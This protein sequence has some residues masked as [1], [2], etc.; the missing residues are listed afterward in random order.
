[1]FPAWAATTEQLPEHWHRKTDPTTGRIYYANELNNHTTYDLAEVMRSAKVPR[2]RT[3]VRVNST[4]FQAVADSATQ[5]AVSD[6]SLSRSQPPAESIATVGGGAHLRG[7]GTKSLID[8]TVVISWDILISNVLKAVSD[9]NYA[10]KNRIVLR[11][12]DQTYIVVRAV[13]DMLASAGCISL[14][15]PIMKDNPDLVTKLKDIMKSISRL[16]LAANV[17]SGVWPPPDAPE[18]LHKEAIEVLLCI[19]NFVQTAQHLN[20]V[21][22]HIPEDEM[23]Q[24]DLNGVALSDQE[25][26]AQLE[27]Y[28]KTIQSRL[29][30]IMTLAASGARKSSLPDMVEAVRQ[31]VTSIGMMLSLLDDLSIN[32]KDDLDHLTLKLA[33]VK[34][35][36]YTSA[37]SMVNM[38]SGGLC[39]R[40]SPVQIHASVLESSTEILVDADY[41]VRLAKRVLDRK[42]DASQLAWQRSDATSLLQSDLSVLQHLVISLS[43]NTAPTPGS[44]VV[45]GY[46]PSVSGSTAHPTVY[47]SSTLGIVE[48]QSAVSDHRTMVAAPSTLASDAFAHYSESSPD[49]TST[50][51]IA[52][53]KTMSSSSS[54]V[55]LGLES[56][57]A[58]ASAS[59]LTHEWSRR[60]GSG[61]HHSSASVSS[62]PTK[63]GNA[64]TASITPTSPPQSGSGMFSDDDFSSTPASTLYGSAFTPRSSSNGRSATTPTTSPDVLSRD[65]LRQVFGNVEVQSATMMELSGLAAAADRTV[66]EASQRK[67]RKFFGD[68]N[69][70]AHSGVAAS[71][72]RRGSLKPFYLLRD[73]RPE[74]LIVSIDG[75]ITG[76]T[77]SALVEHLTPSD[78]PID[79]EYTNAFLMTFR[80]FGT[81]ELFFNTLAARFMMTP[82]PNL[83]DAET[84]LWVEKKRSPVQMR[85]V[86]IIRFWLKKYWDD[87]QDHGCLDYIYRFADSVMSLVPGSKSQRIIELVVKK[88]NQ[89][90]SEI[91]TKLA[92]LTPINVRSEDIPA[93]I[94]PRS[95]FH[96]TLFDIDPV[97]VARQLTLIDFYNFSRI[98][99]LDLLPKTRS[100]GLDTAAYSAE[101]VVALKNISTNISGWVTHTILSERIPSARGG[102]I[103]YFIKIADNCLALGNFN[104]A[105]AVQAGLQCAAIMR[106][107]QSWQT[108]SPK[109]RMRFEAITK[110]TDPSRNFGE[111]RTQLR[112]AALPAIPFIGLVLTDLTFIME[113]NPDYKTDGRLINFDKFSKIARTLQEIKRFQTVPYALR[114]VREIQSFLKGKI[115]REGSQ[116]CLEATF[117]ESLKLEPRGLMEPEVPVKRS[118]NR[119]SMLYSAGIL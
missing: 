56:A 20:I 105:F 117:V 81:P 104:T 43:A 23:T 58:S 75:V 9:L 54:E 72:N 36:L 85:V 82:P 116:V 45:D 111:Y 74:D 78:Q 5:P 80:M 13:R 19:R 48:K 65:K 57:S 87:D 102:I 29:A 103:R 27:S 92:H 89:E 31:C 52:L 7:W 73:H 91:D 35:K 66:T 39:N 33:E 22:C 53:Q 108:L 97:E 60:R 76:G 86:E 51:N 4:T 84:N 68:D 28:A 49:L 71:S 109:I 24:F 38:V 40:F 118:E 6:D 37:T 69:V 88:I 26:A 70:P 95:L 16:V 113:G 99:L 32:P 107:K 55:S 114:E 30:K 94:L 21:L 12:L 3:L 115:E 62:F 64:S 106:L 77:F 110:L 119:L 67:L 63:T 14:D 59:V 83:S 90:T 17:A 25:L 8:R 46:S 2:T 18:R 15:A 1:M 50:G 61:S 101:N 100:K 42:E 98:K 96:F 79:P 41:A 47:S 93:S 34:D 11:F 10:T 112:R 44:V